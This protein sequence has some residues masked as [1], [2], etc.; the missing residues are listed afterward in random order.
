MTVRPVQRQRKSV[1]TTYRW[2][3]CSQ[4]Y[5]ILRVGFRRLHLSHRHH[6]LFR[7]CRKN[8][9]FVC[10]FMLVTDS[11]CFEV[12]YSCRLGPVGTFDDRAPARA[13]HP[14]RAPL[15]TPPD[16]GKIPYFPFLPLD[17][18]RSFRSL[19]CRDL[20]FHA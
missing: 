2:K 10:C 20:F 14:R 15:A 7:F 12:F 13:P 3:R 6:H 16:P 4:G 5:L 11:I 1:Q 9:T 19:S 17:F 8:S 18:P